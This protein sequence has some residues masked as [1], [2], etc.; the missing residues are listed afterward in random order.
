M[1]IFLFPSPCPSAHQMTSQRWRLL[2]LRQGG[3]SVKD[4]AYQFLFVA[5]GLN[6]SDAELKDIFNT[7]L[8]EPVHAWEMGMLGILSLWQFVGYVYHR[9]EEGGLPPLGPPPI[10]IT[11]YLVPSP[12]MTR[13]RR[14]RKNGPAVAPPEAADDAARP[15]AADDTTAA[16]PE[17]AEDT[18]A[19]PEEA[20]HAAASPVEAEESAASPVVAD[21]A[22]A[23][24]RAS[25]E[26]AAH[27]EAA[28]DAAA[29]PPVEANDAAASP[30]VAQNAALPPEAVIPASRSCR[31]RRRRK[32]SSAPHGLEAVP[33]PS[34]GQEAIPE[35]PK[36]L[37]LPAPPKRLALPAPP[38]RLS[39]P[40]P[41]RLLVLPAPLKCL[42]LPVPSRLLVLPGPPWQPA[43]QLAPP[44]PPDGLDPAWSVPP[45]PPWPSTR[46]PVR[47]D[48]VPFG[49]GV[50][51]GFC[52]FGLV[53]FMVLW[54][55]PDT[56]IM[57]AFS[58]E[59]AASSVLESRS[60]SSVCLVS[61]WSVVFGSRHSCL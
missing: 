56:P 60:L 5:E 40:A 53:L 37:A 44:W 35:P 16:C 49:G 38:M 20:G 34:A 25:G 7:S 51:S 29:A 32:A 52:H 42:A 13:N 36:R 59:R 22:A 6:I 18:A 8:N 14:R 45:A 9:G 24:Q 17:V 43:K 27:P 39:L 58:C 30:E 1:G 19:P 54:Q 21:D 41:P 33:E 50:V 12:P 31:R 4:F 57:S 61:C 48:G 10:P 23:P 46:V 11:D 26:A 55:S 2:S 47:P 3:A 15:V 28:D